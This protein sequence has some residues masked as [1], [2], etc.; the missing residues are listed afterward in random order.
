MRVLFVGTVPPPGGDG[1]RRFAQAARRRID[2]GD[3]VEVLSPNPLSASHGSARLD[4]LFLA[5]RLAIA[6]RR[7]D[8]VVLRIEPGLPLHERAGRIERAVALAALGAALGRYSEVTLR[9]DSPIPLPG[10]LGGRATNALWSSVGSIVIADEA[11]RRMLLEVPGVSAESIVVE[12]PA[13]PATRG[14]QHWPA[15]TDPDL[16]ESVLVVVRNRAARDREV[17]RAHAALS[18]E[19]TVTPESALLVADRAVRPTVLGTSSLLARRAL[20]KARR[21]LAS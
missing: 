2:D 15:A 9:L 13:G 21:L 19:D 20:G 17:A 18:A 1:A 10:G 7:F 11:D 14:P 8:A 4:G 16:R 12:E 5:A 6:A 3:V